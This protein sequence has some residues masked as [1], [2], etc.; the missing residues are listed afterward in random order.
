MGGA[1]A[2]IVDD[3]EM[4]IRP[5][6]DHEH[7][8]ERDPADGPVAG[9]GSVLWHPVITGRLDIEQVRSELLPPAH[10]TLDG[11]RQPLISLSALC[12]LQTMRAQAL[13]IWW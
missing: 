12:A 10:G 1:F 13:R 7:N 3:S 4:P 11:T 6:A 9:G 5:G 2:W 8:L